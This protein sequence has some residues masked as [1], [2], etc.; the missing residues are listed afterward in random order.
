MAINL[1][2]IFAQIGLDTSL[3]KAGVSKANAQLAR[4]D[5][6]IGG[7]IKRNQK[8]MLKFGA[9]SVAAVGAIGIAS[10]KMAGDFDQSMRNVN[11]ITKL[12][13]DQF[14]ALKEE[15]IDL[16][17]EVPLSTQQLTEGLFN[18]ASAGVKAADQMNFLTVASKAAV[19]GN[20]D[21]ATTVKGL[22]GVIK[23]Y[24]DEFTNV[25]KV[26]DLFF[27]TNELGVTTFEELAAS[28][29]KVVPIASALGV[30]QEELFAAMATLT[31]VTGNTSE[32]VT[33]LKAAFSNLVK[34]TAD[35]LKISEELGISFDATSIQTLGLKGFLDQV[36][37]ATGGNVE[38]MGKLF[39]SVEGL[40]AILALTGDSAE[41]FS[42]NLDDM[43]IAAGSALD[44]FSEQQKGLNN[45]LIVLKNNIFGVALDIGGKMIP[46][47][48]DFV[49]NI[50][51]L[52]QGTKDNI[53]TGAEWT[54]GIAGTAGV[55]S[56]LAVGITKLIGFLATAAGAFSAAV[57]APIIFTTA[58]DKLSDTVSNK[59][60]KAVLEG[61]SPMQTM[62]EQFNL[63]KDS[64]K[65][66]E[67]GTL[68]WIGVLT[69]G[70]E[71]LKA[72]VEETDEATD[73]SFDY[74]VML[75]RTNQSTIALEG[76]TNDYRVAQED[77]TDASK[78]A[79]DAIQAEADAL[80]NLIDSLFKTFLFN[81][82]LTDSMA[83]SEQAFGDVTEAVKLYGKG[84]DEAESA[85]VDLALALDAQASKLPDII[86][87]IGL[88]TEEELLFLQATQDNID[89]AIEFGIV[90][91]GVWDETSRKIS[92]KIQ[93]T[94]LVDFV[95][96][97]K[98]M[99]AIH[100]TKVNPEI[101]VDTTQAKEALTRL[102]TR[103]AAIKSK[104]IKITT[105]FVSSE[106]NR[107]EKGGEVRGFEAGGAIRGFDN[108]GSTSGRTV[109][110]GERGPELARLPLG[111][112]ISPNNNLG[113]ALRDNQGNQ[114]IVI[115]VTIELDGEVLFESIER[116]SN[117]EEFR[118]IN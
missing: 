116:V 58:M 6:S 19:G 89:K 59:W 100:T 30:T 56:L 23:G 113:Q 22:T 57:T 103:L 13:E 84:S 28:M 114:E 64:A 46:A 1:G 104:N 91:A 36:K 24:G 86:N 31:G 96:L 111:T 48:T 38:T 18:V 117:Q 95:N 39:G 77:A 41:K 35:A 14:N 93:G 11:T 115:P 9:A 10:I 94:I 2:T 85:L 62:W 17:R 63:L 47:L 67:D 92:E 110:V 65:L 43:G 105:T 60:V 34:P 51:E 42:S 49:T 75:L 83:N 20:A 106:Q 108:G 118:R 54:L 33:Q 45:Q 53:A 12:S 90:E 74:N 44:A 70:K 80:D 25:D 82:D 68:S 102:I 4:A 40:G 101:T 71:K 16:S 37:E 50:N 26:A 27:K 88:L 73:A 32:V 15:V 5:K 78:D 66:V 79:A 52:D 55:I 76:T 87:K 109:L 61:L 72:L 3:L 99:E 29:G 81:A 8:N 21:L 107:F 97:R 112:R 98:G 7:F 69:T